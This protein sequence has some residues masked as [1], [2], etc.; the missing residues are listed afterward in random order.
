MDEQ[1][2]LTAQSKAVAL[3][4]FVSPHTDILHYKQRSGYLEFGVK[5]FH[6]QYV[7]RI[8]R[9]K[10]YEELMW[11]FMQTPS[12]SKEISESY[13]AFRNLKK[14]V[15][16]KDKTFLHI[17]DGAYARTGAIFTFFSNSENHSIDPVLNLG[18]LKQWQQRYSVR[19]LFLHK[20]RFEDLDYSSFVN[21]II[22]LVHSHVDIVPVIKKIPQWSIIYSNSCCYPQQQFL[23]TEFMIKNKIG[24]IVNREDY[25]I[26][27]EKRKI[28]IYVN[29]AG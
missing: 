14:I 24:C 13:S 1:T 23:T 5:T 22:T 3:S 7:D 20:E 12:P 9:S 16:L 27:S 8:L 11:L 2:N 21:P 19:N 17:G 29:N 25:G 4:S 10:S 15:L 26:L 28:A 18:K 6:W